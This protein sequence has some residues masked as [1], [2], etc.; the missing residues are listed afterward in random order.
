MCTFLLELGDCNV[1]PWVSAGMGKGEA[2]PP[3][4]GAL[5]F[6]GNVEKCFFAANVV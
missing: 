6:P 1:K 2:M 5:A 3:S 4:K